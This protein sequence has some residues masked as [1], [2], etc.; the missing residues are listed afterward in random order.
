MLFA[1]LEVYTSNMKQVVVISGGSQGLGLAT[2][3]RL[4]KDY[5]VIILARDEAKLREAAKKLDC[6]YFVCDV[7]NS[8]Q[9]AEVV[10]KIAKKY[11]RIDCLINNA[12]TYV[13]G[14]VEDLPIEEVK[15]VFATNV[16]GLMQ[17]TSA[18]LPH[19][20]RAKTGVIVNVLS[21]AALRGAAGDSVYHASKYAA[22]G[23]T[24]SI[25]E[26][27]KPFNVRVSAIY[28]GGFTEGDDNSGNIAIDE[29]A[30]GIEFIVG[31]GPNTV[32]PKLVIKHLN[33]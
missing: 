1:L 21:T 10:S 29:V 2:A 15:K 8:K 16:F 6:A 30:R 22:D 11:D 13:S 5:Q 9:V 27:L 28:P 4:T 12:G 7:A 32:V 26:E 18:V 31:A 17:L 33:F 23:F 14:A 25:A 24:Q 3:Q 20:K 19:M